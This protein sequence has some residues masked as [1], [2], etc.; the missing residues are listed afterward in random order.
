MA[1][2]EATGSGDLG[3]L[4]AALNGRLPD[5]V[6]QPGRLVCPKGSA[7]PAY[8]LSD[9]PVDAGTWSV[10]Q[11]EHPGSGLWPLLLEPLSDLEG[12]RER[13]WVVGEVD[14]RPVPAVDDLDPGTVFADW[15]DRYLAWF[16]E[17]L[18]G[19]GFGEDWPGLAPAG[20]AWRTSEAA[21]DSCAAA[22]VT[23][24][25]RLG[26]VAVDR[27]ADALAVLG[28]QGA[29]E[30]AEEGPAQL[31]AVLRSW[32]DRF[33]ARLVRVGFNSI[34]VVVAALPASEEDALLLAAEHYAFAPEELLGTGWFLRRYARHLM[35][36]GAWAFGWD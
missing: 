9:D 30:H 33:G 10:L 32:E 20:R 18:E 35:D 8:W 14:P 17:A 12:Y 2:S 7:T 25:S 27:S 1:A 29:V 26:L 11:A 28:W 3:S 31:S 24:L 15:W 22:V 5:G 16:G 13:P 19:S 6:L 36:A 23:P 34:R 4:V 21:A